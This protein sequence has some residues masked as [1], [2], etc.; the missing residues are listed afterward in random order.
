MTT[1]TIKI[2]G[3]TNKRQKHYKA[4]GS[5]NKTTGNQNRTD[6]KQLS[7]R[8]RKNKILA[9]LQIIKTNIDN[10][11]QEVKKLFLDFK[12]IKNN[13]RGTIDQMQDLEIIS[14]KI[15]SEEKIKQVEKQFVVNRG[16]QAQTEL[17]WTG[18]WNEM[19]RTIENNKNN[20]SN[21]E[22]KTRNETAEGS[23]TEQEEEGDQELVDNKV[24]GYL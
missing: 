4:R 22:S 24:D 16:E 5:H 11:K 10:I 8:H 23:S 13:W 1:Q 20:I 7:S 6:G 9:K 21:L 2:T 15:A 19:M 3:R 17:K 12:Q 18:K 14:A